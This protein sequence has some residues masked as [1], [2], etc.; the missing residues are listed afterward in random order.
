MSE[1]NNPVTGRAVANVNGN[2]VANPITGKVF[3]YIQDGVMVS[4]ITGR[5]LA[6]VGEGGN[7]GGG[8]S[9]GTSGGGGGGSDQKTVLYMP[10]NGNMN[11]YGDLRLAI[12]RSQAYSEEDWGY[13]DWTP[14]YATGVFSGEQALM[15]E[16]TPTDE[17]GWPMYP[18]T[19]KFIE[20]PLSARFLG[21]DFTW[22][23]W[24]YCDS[25]TSMY[26]V[27][28]NK[29]GCGFKTSD[30]FQTIT[31]NLPN[32]PE[33]YNN[34]TV[35][36]VQNAWN[37]IAAVKV[38]TSIK[39]FVGGVKKYDGSLTTAD[40]PEE[41]KGTSLFVGSREEES[42]FKLNHLRILNYPLWTENFTPPAVGSYSAFMK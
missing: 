21:G 24:I 5:P 30:G 42:A 39:I 13:V 23:F 32:S 3:A 2:E 35:G 7:G 6:I 28:F 11:I 36:T 25:N 27:H 10:F 1:V 19:Y 34:I 20:L 26:S 22:D 37:H 33:R 31:L 14:E 4:A 8:S 41:L 12:A 29:I 9:D 16:K 15:F 18:A 17:E 38:G 40:T